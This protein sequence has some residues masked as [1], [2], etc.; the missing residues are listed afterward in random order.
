MSYVGMARGFLYCAT[1]LGA[2]PGNSEE[3]RGAIRE[4]DPIT[5]AHSLFFSLSLSLSLSLPLSPVHISHA[6][7]APFNPTEPGLAQPMG[8]SLA[9]LGWPTGPTVKFLNCE[10]G[11]IDSRDSHICEEQ[12]GGTAL[13]SCIILPR[14][15]M[16]HEL[17]CS[18]VKK[19]EAKL[20]TSTAGIFIVSRPR[21]TH[22]AN[23]PNQ[24]HGPELG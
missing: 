19:T 10:H 12:T 8:V 3:H 14:I 6:V 17:T 22:Q 20:N 11:N 21:E 9:K 7:P 18:Y 16:Q 15:E 4:L 23:S 24:A 2:D 5:L 1:R 13:V